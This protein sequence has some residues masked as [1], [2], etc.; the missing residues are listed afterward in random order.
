[1]ANEEDGRE[2]SLTGGRDEEVEELR[3]EPLERRMRK[4]EESMASV[5]SCEERSGVTSGDENTKK[6][7]DL[8]MRDS[9]ATNQS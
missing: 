9:T 6:T 5:G 8:R 3:R 2:S 4:G 7:E 1:M